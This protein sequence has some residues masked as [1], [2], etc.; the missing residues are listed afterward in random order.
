METLP[1]HYNMIIKP[2]RLLFEQRCA[3]MHQMLER[4]AKHPQVVFLEEFPLVYPLLAKSA[5]Y[6]GDYSSV[7]YDFLFF[8]R[9][10]FFLGEKKAF[11]HSCGETAKA[12]SFFS[13]INTQKHLREK[14]R[15]MYA[16]TFG[17]AFDPKALQEAFSN[18]NKV[19]N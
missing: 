17:K 12:E 7:G 9:P 16:Y 2:H 3:K 8:N 19:A 15:Q 10:M 6:L 5:I 4:F 13:Q 18:L 1:S 11:L 14:R